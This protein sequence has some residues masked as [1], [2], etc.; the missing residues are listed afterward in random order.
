MFWHMVKC[1]TG[2]PG[3]SFGTWS[4]VPQGGEGI[5]PLPRTSVTLDSNALSRLAVLGKSYLRFT[6][7]PLLHN[8]VY[9]YQECMLL[10]AGTGIEA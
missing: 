10:S 7:D 6:W 3:S 8:K 5:K 9:K 4:K 2:R 1:P